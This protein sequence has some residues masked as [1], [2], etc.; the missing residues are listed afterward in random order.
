METL[1]APSPRAPLLVMHAHLTGCDRLNIHAEMSVVA[2]RAEESF[3][4]L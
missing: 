1:E 3:S 2:W 4:T